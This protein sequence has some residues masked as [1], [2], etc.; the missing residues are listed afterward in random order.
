MLIIIQPDPQLMITWE[1]EK[2]IPENW[3]ISLELI[4]L[5]FMVR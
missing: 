4:T 2:F 1:S 5:D 3:T